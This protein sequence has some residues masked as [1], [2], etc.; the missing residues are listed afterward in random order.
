MKNKGFTLLE[1]LLVITLL[2]IAFSVI[3]YVYVSELKGNIYLS[4]KVNRY[5]EY[6]AVKNQLTKQLL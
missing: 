3:G 2:L 6:L 5:I 4:S 1:L